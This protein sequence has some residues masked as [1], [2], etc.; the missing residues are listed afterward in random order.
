MVLQRRQITD[1][2]AIAKALDYSLRRWGAPA[3][4]LDDGQL[5]IDNNWIK[6]QIR[7]I[8]IESARLERAASGCS[9]EPDPKCQAKQE[10]A[11]GT[12]VALR[13]YR[14]RYSGM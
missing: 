12:Q 10:V 4:F 14:N 2:S 11:V 3:R 1:G 7:P 9:H 8:A 6:N 5:P 13:H